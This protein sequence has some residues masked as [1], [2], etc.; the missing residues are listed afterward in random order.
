[1][2]LVSKHVTAYKPCLTIPHLSEVGC[3]ETIVLLNVVE[4]TE[5]KEDYL[6]VFFFLWLFYLVLLSVTVKTLLTG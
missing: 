3:C 2:Q 4:H 1:M 6:N 5:K